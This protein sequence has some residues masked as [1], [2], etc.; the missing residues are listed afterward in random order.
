MASPA[1]IFSSPGVTMTDSMGD[2]ERTGCREAPA[3]IPTWSTLWETRSTSPRGRGR[4]RSKA[5][6]A[7]RSAPIDAT[8]NG[9]VNVLTGNT[10]ANVLDGGSGADTLNGGKGN[11]TYLIDDPADRV[12]ESSGQGV[13]HVISTVTFTLPSNVENLT[14]SGPS[15]L[16]ATGN[17][18]ANVLVGNSADNTLN[19]GAGADSMYGGVGDDTYLIDNADDTVFE[20]A[21]EGIDTVRSSRTYALTPNVEHLVLTGTA[22]INGTG[23]GLDNSISGTTAANVLSGGAGADVL[24]GGK[25]SDT[26]LFGRGG[27]ADRIVEN[28]TTKGN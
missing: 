8:G 2:R 21:D 19:G 3:T 5:P 28:D 7:T 9:L 13:D 26:Y 10:A 25:G 22:A 12:V 15:A 23:N 4:L 14:L 11:D 16:D 27:G 6:S 1:T 24:A 18:L 17:A 20:L